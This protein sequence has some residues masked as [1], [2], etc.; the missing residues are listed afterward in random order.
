MRTSWKILFIALLFLC[1]GSIKAEM[2][3]GQPAGHSDVLTFTNPTA[4][5][6]TNVYRSTGTCASGGAFTK[7][8]TGVTSLTTYTDASPLVGQQCYYVTASFNGVESSPSNK[9]DVTSL[10]LLPAPTGLV[11]SAN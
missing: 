2:L 1:V 7:I 11:G 3:G 6:T 8:A 5:S 10:V 4:G 9:I